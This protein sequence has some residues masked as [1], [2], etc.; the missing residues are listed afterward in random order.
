MQFITANGRGIVEIVEIWWK[1]M[2]CSLLR[3]L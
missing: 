1:N 3:A 2:L